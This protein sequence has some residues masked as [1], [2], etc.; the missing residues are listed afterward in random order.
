MIHKQ[1]VSYKQVNCPT[2][3]G[4]LTKG[5]ESRTKM[6]HTM[7]I[8]LQKLQKDLKKA[9]GYKR[10]PEKAGSFIVAN[11]WSAEPWLR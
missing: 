9:I 1:D 3:V 8:L 5:I 6:G 7:F 2:N 11:V 4:S 10:I